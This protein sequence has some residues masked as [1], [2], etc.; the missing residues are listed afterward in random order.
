MEY[1][2]ERPDRIYETDL[3]CRS[4]MYVKIVTCYDATLRYTT[5]VFEC[6]YTGKVY[7]YSKVL[8]WVEWDKL[9]YKNHNKIYDIWKKGTEKQLAAIASKK[10]IK[11]L[12]F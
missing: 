6:D 8:Q 2:Y 12:K 9:D 11:R 4:G 10:Y 7:D 5:H 3:Q 1:L